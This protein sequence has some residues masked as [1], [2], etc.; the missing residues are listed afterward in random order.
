MGNGGGTGAS[1]A[2][3]VVVVTSDATVV[4]V[5]AAVV[6][7]ASTVVVVVVGATVVVVV[8]GAAWHACHVPENDLSYSVGLPVE[9][10]AS[11]TTDHV[12]GAVC[13]QLIVLLYDPPK[14]VTVAT[15]SMVVVTLLFVLE[16]S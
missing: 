3:W 12:C 7:V 4:V 6:V 1:E 15:L 13:D 16:P 2:T 5:A 9:R 11:I 8:V 10:F 14:S